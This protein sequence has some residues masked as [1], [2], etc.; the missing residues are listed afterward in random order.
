MKN[1]NDILSSWKEYQSLPNSEWRK[2]FFCPETGG[3]LV[4]S[5]KRIEEAN[6]NP[7][8]QSKLKKEHDMCMVFAQSGL[9]IK[10]FE[11]GKPDGSY[12]V[13]CNNQKGDLKK[14]KGGGNIVRY[15]K[16]ATR[17]QG[18]E[19]VLFE[20]VEWKSE[21]RDTVSEMIRKNL[22]GYYFVSGIFVVHNF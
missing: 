19:I 4:T 13:V 9:K 2:D 7:K 14:T 16:Y 12:D 18:A 21:I 5:W 20:F 17:E 22:H 15:A 10:H 8:E 11:D 3:Y 6:K 1:T